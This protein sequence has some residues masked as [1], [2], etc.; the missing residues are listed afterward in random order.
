MER[1]GR[2]DIAV[3]NAGKEGLGAIADVTAEAFAAIFETNVLG[4]LLSLKYEFRIM[5]KQGKGSIVNVSSVYGHV[6]FV[7]GGSV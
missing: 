6:G 2:I 1:F 5:Q 3:N 7:H 4:T